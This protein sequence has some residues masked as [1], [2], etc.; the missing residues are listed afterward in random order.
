MDKLSQ[1]LVDGDPLWV[2][3]VRTDTPQVTEISDRQ[4]VEFEE[5]EPGHFYSK[6]DITHNINQ[7]CTAPE[8]AIWIAVY[9]CETDQVPASIA[10]AYIPLNPYSL[11]FSVHERV[12]TPIDVIRRISNEMKGSQPETHPVLNP[13]EPK[14]KGGWWWQ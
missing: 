1:A 2:S 8:E 9:F 14:Q 10:R 6:E 13:P 3:L 12:V 5:K 11:Q 4:K 7:A